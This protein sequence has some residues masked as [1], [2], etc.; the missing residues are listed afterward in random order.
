MKYLIIFML[1]ILTSCFPTIMYRHKIKVTYTD[2]TT[3][4]LDYSSDYSH[5]NL[6]NGCIKTILNGRYK[7]VSCDIRNFKTLSST[8]I[9]Y[10]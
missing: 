7:T 5:I 9:I 4:V 1:F 6:E 3:A 8:R 2:A 10:D